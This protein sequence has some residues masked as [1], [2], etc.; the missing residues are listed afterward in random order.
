M[1]KANIKYQYF[2]FPVGLLKFVLITHFEIMKYFKLY[3][4]ILKNNALVRNIKKPTY[5]LV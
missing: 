2:S 3:D 4:G 5:I 1:Y